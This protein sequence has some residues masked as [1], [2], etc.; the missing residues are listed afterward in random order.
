[1]IKLNLVSPAQKKQLTIRSLSL[2][3]ENGL[4]L[5]LFLLTILAIFAI[6]LKA[7][8][9]EL[10]AAN[11]AALAALAAEHNE[12]TQKFQ[13]LNQ[14]ITLLE[15][16]KNENYGWDLLLGELATLTPASVALLELTA[17][18]QGQQINL[19]GFADQRDDLIAFQEKLKNSGLLSNL[20]SPLENYLQKEKINF[21]LRANL[22]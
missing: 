21:E 13:A 3:V 6:P 12:Q 15:Q 11:T 22:K 8:L 17:S 7:K 20:E 19:I 9:E 16:V 4:G 2:A 1:M 14:K 18:S 10:S 5:L